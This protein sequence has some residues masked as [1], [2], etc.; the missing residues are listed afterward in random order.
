MSGSSSII[1]TVNR[2]L[3]IIKIVL[4]KYLKYKQKRQNSKQL[5]QNQNKKTKNQ[6]DKIIKKQIPDKNNQATFK[7]YPI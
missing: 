7:G 6:N 1:K 5:K 4:H 3:F 2:D